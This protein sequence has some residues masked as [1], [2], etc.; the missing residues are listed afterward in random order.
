MSERAVHKDLERARRAGEP[1]RISREIDDADHLDGL[2][3]ERFQPLPDVDLDSTKGLIETFP[4]LGVHIERIDPHVCLAE[5]DE[6]ERPSTPRMSVAPPSSCV[7]MT[8]GPQRTGDGPAD[9]SPAASPLFFSSSGGSNGLQLAFSPSCLPTA[10]LLTRITAH[11][12]RATTEGI[13]KESQEWSRSAAS[14]RRPRPARVA[15]RQVTSHGHDGSR[16]E[17]TRIPSARIAPPDMM[18]VPHQRRVA[19]GSNSGA[20]RPR[21]GSSGSDTARAWHTT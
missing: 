6:V 15:T 10:R 13:R 9:R 19:I 5:L 18:T 4:L 8:E 21:T 1:V 12:E 16:R 3:G 2:R 11:C 14:R 17:N 20:G 7:T